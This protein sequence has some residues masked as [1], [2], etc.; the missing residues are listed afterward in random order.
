MIVLGYA[1]AKYLKTQHMSVTDDRSGFKMRVRHV[2]KVGNIATVIVSTI[3]II[4]WLTAGILYKVDDLNELE[5]Y[6]M[7]SYVCTRTSDDT[8]THTVGS[9]SAMCIQMR[10]A[11]WAVVVVGVLELTAP[12]IVIWAICT[13]RKRGVYAEI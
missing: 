12:G 8:L 9:F 2:T 10:Y 7:P 13:P 6:D 11:W 1:I 5:H 3:A 4:L